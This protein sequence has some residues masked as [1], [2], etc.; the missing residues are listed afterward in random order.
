MEPKVLVLDEPTAGLD[1]R[2]STR[3]MRTVKHL[4]DEGGRTVVLVS[5]NMIDISF[6][7]ER[8]IVMEEGRIV[9]DGPVETIFGQYAER[10]RELGLD[11]PPVTAVLQGLRAHGAAVP[12]NLLTVPEAA[13]SIADW[14]RSQKHV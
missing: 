11:V 13:G 3:I 5:H 4:H 10:L 2:G 1:P 14:M 8:V 12:G 7:A 9:L 6:L